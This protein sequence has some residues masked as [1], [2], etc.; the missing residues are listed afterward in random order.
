MILDSVA[1]GSTGQKFLEESQGFSKEFN[2]RA[3][4]IVANLRIE[5]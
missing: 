4:R 3:K 1:R 2:Q 5:S